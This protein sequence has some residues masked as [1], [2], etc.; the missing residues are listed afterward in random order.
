M[1]DWIPMQV[2]LSRR[3]EVIQIAFN[4]DFSRHQVV[5]MLLEVWGWFSAESVD[6]RVDADVDALVDAIGLP[7][8]FFEGGVSPSSE[9]PSACAPPLNPDP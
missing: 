1:A 4:C 3:S 9:V 5:G 6:G 8:C 2:D 7:R